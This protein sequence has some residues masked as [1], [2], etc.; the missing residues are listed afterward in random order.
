MFLRNTWYAASWSKDLADKPVARTV[1][2]EKLVLFR[3]AGGAAGAL[4]DKCC[5]RAA[6]LSLGKVEGEHL[7][8]GY[9]G[10]LF[11]ADGQCVEVPIQANVPP[12]ARVKSYPA[13]EKWNIVW[14]WMGEPARAD[15][16]RIPELPWLDSAEW[17][18]TPGYLHIDANAQLIIDNLLDFTHVPYIH[19]GTLAGDDKERSVLSKTERLNDGVRVGRWLIDVAPPP[20][21]AAAS[22]IGGKVDRWQL[23]TWSP[24][25]HVIMDV[26]IAKTGTGAPEGDRR[27]GASIWSTHLI[28][29]ETERSSHYHFAMARNFRRDDPEASRILY[30]GSRATF[31]QDRDMIEAQQR[32]L[33]AGALEGLVDVTGDAAQL[34]VRR[35][36]DDM[37]RAERSEIAV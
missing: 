7:R 12:G 28:T 2:G 1:L 34:Q 11:G 25:S 32:N 21:F 31:V 6:P 9:H 17:V 35:M 3:T 27:H 23:A 15:E 26:G 10:L 22:G 16:A 37:I 13:V 29:P 24:P 30:E 4:E 8:C 5:H 36:L 33:A 18:A 19:P 14:L 20:I